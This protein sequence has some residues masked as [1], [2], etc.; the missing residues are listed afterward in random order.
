[1]DGKYILQRKLSAGGGGVV[2]RSTD[3]HGNEVA[4]KTLTW[5]RLKLK[6]FSTERFKNEFAIFKSLV[7]PNIARI[8]D[9]GYDDTHDVY[10]FTS[11]LLEGGDLR[12]FINE[13]IEVIEPL[14][15]QALR[16]LEFLRNAGLLHLDIKP[17]NFLVRHTTEGNQLVLI[18]FGLAT[19]RPSNK[20]G[21]TA[22][23]MPPE[24]VVRRIS[25]L[26]EKYTM[27]AP[28][29]RSDLYSL[30]VTFYHILTG[31]Q[32]F[33]V[34]SDATGRI[35]QNAT[36]KN[37][38]ERG[39][40]PPPS[41]FRK[42][43]PPYLDAII[44]KLMARDPDDR[45]PAAAIAMQAL[46]Y[47]SPRELEPEDMASLL[48]Y[49]PKQGKMIGRASEL[50]KAEEAIAKIAA[51]TPHAR[52]ILCIT[53]KRGTGRTRFLDH[54]KPFAQRMEMN[55]HLVDA[56][57]AS[58][59][60]LAQLSSAGL[61]TGRP[62]ALLIDGVDMLLASSAN[63]DESSALINQLREFIYRA[64]RS[65]RLTHSSTAPTLIAFTINTE[66]IE[67]E[68]ALSLLD[69][70]EEMLTTIELNNF[71]VD[72]VTDYLTS[73]IG[74]GISS[75]A[76]E[77]L[78]RV[79]EGNPL[80]MTE[81]L[82]HMISE[83]MLFSLAGRPDA[84]TWEAMGHD[85]A[86]M[87]PPPSLTEFT[88]GRYDKLDLHTK[89]VAAL[90]ACWSKPVTTEDLHHTSDLSHIEDELLKLIGIN[91]IS[92]MQ[93]NGGKFTF[94]NPV[95]AHIIE[96]HLPENERT[97]MH[98]RIANYLE[99]HFRNDTHAID[100]H[101]AHGA[102]QSRRFRALERL[103]HEAE[104]HRKSLEAT[105][106]LE[107]LLNEVPHNAWDMRADVLI[108][109]GRAYEWAYMPKHAT[110]AFR[111]LINL[112]APKEKQRIFKV[113]AFEQLALS[114]IRRRELD[115]A[116][117]YLHE[118]MSILGKN[119]KGLAMRLRLRNFL[120]GIELRDGHADEAIE[121]F[122][123]NLK[124][125]EALTKHDLEL[126]NNNELGEALLHAHRVEDAHQILT[127]ELKEAEASGNLERACSRQYLLGNVLSST[128]PR[129]FEGALEHY[130]KAFEIARTHRMLRMQVRLYNSIANLKL[131]AGKFDEAIDHY[132]KGLS[133][134]EQIDSKTTSV[135][136]M[137]GLSRSYAHKHATDDAIEYFEAALDFMHGPMGTSAG[138]I[139][140]FA[141][142]IYAHL[143]DAY[144][145]KKNYERAMKYLEKAKELDA[146]EELSADIRYSIYGTYADVCVATG[147]PD[148]AKS[149]VP[150]LEELVM[151][152]PVAQ[153]HL[154][155]LQKKLH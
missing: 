51:K 44:M 12:N 42:D 98:S 135:E 6:D 29:H 16:S 146:S 60:E 109:L 45:Y 104:N 64:R 155:A 31:Q 1:M 5:S 150:L 7:H 142:T 153:K 148:E 139:K 83:G 81:Q 87:P 154:T 126:L 36:L 49:L 39:E 96:S 59:D 9:F 137:V 108:R 127:S 79:T 19:F 105:E 62:T 63:A 33:H 15:L 106:Y 27:P 20:P 76:V 114:A 57:H 93:E 52:P 121:Q 41:A 128:E 138:L 66:N 111:R 38:V 43:I 65:M 94:E 145:T 103:A 22:N 34:K 117:L 149:L 3:T 58:L 90:M 48:S 144:Y 35:D 112:R 132:Q 152:F 10:Y 107:A 21:G 40:I 17:Q 73:L 130:E 11:E 69:I 119:P 74:E 23:Y 118:A 78:H 136:L 56:P 4:L 2:W 95:V 122:E 125:A 13:P 54:L 18:D 110:N 120:A 72:E 92:R 89:K 102:N 99:R 67:L 24:V 131:N 141:P 101:R 80:V 14:L 116:R 134:S 151:A 85:F 129:D 133:L 47:R 26:A 86:S 28:D 46:R 143:G 8:F 124:K 84:S 25:D 147:H 55:T 70:E 88:I 123:D 140:H 75:D 32:P 68:K 91:L 82:E 100:Y 113:R 77:T 97:R 37:H 71:T 53:G 50:K 61:E 30:G 115:D